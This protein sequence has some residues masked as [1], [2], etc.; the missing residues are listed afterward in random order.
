MIEIAEN[1][2]LITLL[3]NPTDTILDTE[4]KSIKLYS[5]E[6]NLIIVDVV[7]KMREKSQ[8]DILK[9]SFIDVEKYAFDHSKEYNFSDVEQVKF[10]ETKEQK[11]YI[12]FDPYD[13]APVILDNDNDFILSN[14]IIGYVVYRTK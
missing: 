12:C 14:K 8:F 9:L 6:D 13:E 11:Y 5:D 1:S 2:T 3:D 4:I 7:L 10:F